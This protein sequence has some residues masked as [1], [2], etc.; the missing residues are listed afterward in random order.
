MFKR[1]LLFGILIFAFSNS[2]ANKPIIEDSVVFTYGDCVVTESD[3]K[4]FAYILNIDFNKN[5][6]L[7]LKKVIE[8][9]KRYFCL[10]ENYPFEGEFRREFPN[11]FYQLN[12]FFCNKFLPDKNVFKAGIDN[13]LLM[14]NLFKLLFVLKYSFLLG[15]DGQ[16]DCMSQPVY[17][18]VN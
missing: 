18:T 8:I 10:K 16:N 11:L 3:L 12:L 17:L 6:K 14:T 5:R 9:E 2:F 7:V 1:L 13:K 4:A 15:N